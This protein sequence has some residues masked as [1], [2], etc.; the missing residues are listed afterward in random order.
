MNLF[1]YNVGCRCVGRLLISSNKVIIIE[2]ESPPHVWVY[3]HQMCIRVLSNIAAVTIKAGLV[4]KS[5]DIIS[6][7]GS[8]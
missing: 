7:D 1:I 8:Q 4:L 5:N 3:G 2:I 6:S